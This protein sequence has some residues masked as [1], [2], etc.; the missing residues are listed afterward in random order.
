MDE[1]VAADDAGQLIENVLRRIVGL[2]NQLQE[3]LLQA[4]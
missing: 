4:R 2:L 3:P 1:A